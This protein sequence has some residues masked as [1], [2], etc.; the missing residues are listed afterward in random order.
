[1]YSR[2]V[3]LETLRQQSG[4]VIASPPSITPH[5]S[6]ID[7]SIT[8]IGTGTGS[9]DISIDAA[10]TDTTHCTVI[11]GNQL[12]LQA[13]NLIKGNQHDV[14]HFSYIIHALNQAQK[15]GG[16]PA[17]PKGLYY[18]SMS[19]G[20]RERFRG[21]LD[22]FGDSYT[23]P[24]DAQEL[25]LMFQI[26]EDWFGTTA[27]TGGCVAGRNC[28]SSVD[29]LLAERAAAV[30]VDARW[31]RELKRL[32]KLQREKTGKRK[33]VRKEEEVEEKEEDDDH[34]EESKADRLVELRG[35]LLSLKRRERQRQRELQE[36]IESANDLGV[37]FGCPKGG[38]TAV[39]WR[40]VLDQH[41]EPD[42]LEFL[43]GT[44]D[45]WV[46][47]NEEPK[48]EPEQELESGVVS[49]V[50]SVYTLFCRAWPTSANGTGTKMIV[51]VDLF[52]S[53]GNPLNLGS[54]YTPTA[55]WRGNTEKNEL[56]AAD[57]SNMNRMADLD[58]VLCHHLHF[59]CHRLAL[60]GAQLT[61]DF[62]V[63]VT[64]VITL[65]PSLPRVDNQP[66]RG[67]DSTDISYQQLYSDRMTA[68]HVSYV[69]CTSL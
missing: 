58:E 4:I 41:L 27:G 44:K 57:G 21:Q 8:G 26:H 34:D 53:F 30:S 16:A 61:A 29:L 3:L 56:S 38:D 15:E 11:V 40:Q 46:G 39:Q 18:L 9:T 17:P 67:G 6:E 45:V 60:Y 37:V 1:M 47:G 50:G 2:N 33:R 51:Y 22:C 49:P 14:V 5:S 48:P 42:E 19:R 68:I 63:D 54:V 65:S 55:D 66:E 32:E 62:H 52:S 59:V 31:A 13:C 28:L 12:S 64:H 25:A 24:V 20:T 23:D 35:R 69:I 10:G 7:T 43:L 36:C